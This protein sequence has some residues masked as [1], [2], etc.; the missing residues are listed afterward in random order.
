ML[1]IYFAA[2][3]GAGLGAY[4]A[5]RKGG[6]VKDIAQYVVVYMLIFGMIALFYSIFTARGA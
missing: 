2:L 3:F 6:N 4:H 1:L 5:M